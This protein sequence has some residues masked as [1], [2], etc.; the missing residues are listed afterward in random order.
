MLVAH[1]ISRGMIVKIML[2]AIDFDNQSL[3]QAD[4]VDNEAVTR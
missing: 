3:L 4:K 1:S 2:A